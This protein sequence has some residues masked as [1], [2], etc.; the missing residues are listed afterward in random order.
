MAYSKNDQLITKFSQDLG[1][2]CERVPKSG[3]LDQDGKHR[4]EV[5]VT[6]CYQ[7]QFILWYGLREWLKRQ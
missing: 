2:Y 4:Y 7:P 5:P 3:G 6:T 1:T